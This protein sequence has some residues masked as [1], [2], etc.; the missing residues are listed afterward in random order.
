VS[1]KIDY[2]FPRDG[3]PRLVDSASLVNM[4][5]LAEKIGVARSTAANYPKRYEDFPEAI[6]A[7]GVIGIKLYDWAKVKAWFDA[8]F[9]ERY[10][11][12][13]GQGA[14]IEIETEEIS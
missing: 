12:G 10:P 8:N 9:A 1:K 7:P 6:E 11:R 3:E 5:G 4:A 13:F 14:L 2:Y